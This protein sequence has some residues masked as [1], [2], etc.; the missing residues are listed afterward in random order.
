ALCCECGQLRTYRCAMRARAALGHLG[1]SWDRWE[2]RMVGA[3]KCAHCGAITV[4]ALLLDPA[5]PCNFDEREQALALGDH[6]RDEYE[7]MTDLERLRRE[8][9]EGF[10]RNL[11][12]LARK[13][14]GERQDRVPNLRHIATKNQV[15]D[16]KGLVALC[17]YDGMN[18][19]ID[20]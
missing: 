8:Y 13:V 2:R 10:D 7:R 6:P 17:G 15:P 4:H 9:Q 12:T 19:A 14:F 5:G 3:L 11:R 20:L 18:F 1:G 16:R